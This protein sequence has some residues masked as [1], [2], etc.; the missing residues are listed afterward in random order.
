[1]KITGKPYAGKL[2]VRI[3]EGEGEYYVLSF[4]TLLL[5]SL[6]FKL[7]LRQIKKS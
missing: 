4:S 6:K 2:H 5:Y 7:L 1:M 3:D